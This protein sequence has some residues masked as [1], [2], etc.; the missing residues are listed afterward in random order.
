MPDHSGPL[1]E[2]KR[3]HDEAYAR[4]GAAARELEEA[5]RARDEARSFIHTAM[6]CARQDG[7]TWT[8]IG[9]AIGVSAQAASQMFKR[10]AEGR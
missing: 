1:A 7:M 8:Q 6:K 2:A 9:A 10:Y 4:A 3:A 5:R